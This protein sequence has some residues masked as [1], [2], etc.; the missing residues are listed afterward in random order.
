M[1]IKLKY[2]LIYLYTLLTF[3]LIG[4]ISI[5]SSKV[6]MKNF[7]EYVSKNQEEEIRK[8][9]DEVTELY[10]KSKNI[11]YMDLYDIGVRAL[12][13]GLILM[14]NK[15]Y[16]NQIICMSEILVEES[17]EM[18]LQMENTLKMAYPHFEGQ[19]QEDFFEII[20]N[21]EVYGYITIGY[22]GPIYYTEFDIIFLKAVKS[23]IF[24]IGL[25]FLC[26][27]TIIMYIF[28]HRLAKPIE[29]VSKK[30]EEIGNGNYNKNIELKSDTIEL[31]NLIKS[32]NL[33]S[34]NLE[35]QKKVKKQLAENYTH[36][37]RTPI[38]C[39]LTTLEGMREG[40]FEIS[41]ERLDS[42]Y[43]EILHI[44][45]LVS[46]VDKLVESRDFD[47]I[48]SKNNF[49]LSILVKSCIDN[50][51]RL[52]SSKN[53]SLNLRINEENIIIN[54]DEEKIKSVVINLLSN[55]LKYTD[56]NGMVDVSIEKDEEYVI[57]KIKD[58]GI[59][60]EEKYKELIFEEMYRIEK[61]R[62]R[63]VE[64][65]GLGLSICK[66][67]IDAHNGKI[68]VNSMLNKGSEF[69]VKLPKK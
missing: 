64:G 66:N 9:V 23:S 61:S 59:G 50:F 39:V 58:N 45:K 34:N 55:A 3:S 42:L 31:Y 68:E 57:L 29:K 67:I 18:L 43:L 32:I 2:K 16:D 4:I 28:A 8:I 25:I 63:N 22:Y 11:N 12:D 65:F 44:S 10:G 30:T 17:T 56:E 54:A 52:Y 6:F 21:D 49:D 35:N 7:N 37:I 53:I 38:T 33:L 15:D 40:V 69:I 26:I 47:I 5:T 41:Q 27:S 24:K 1:K 60:I 62:V 20:K 48:L 19:Y 13:N 14:V 36:E 46:G 51:D